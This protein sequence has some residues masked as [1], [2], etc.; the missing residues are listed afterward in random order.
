MRIR[1]LSFILLLSFTLSAYSQSLIDEQK[2]KRFVS[3]AEGALHE[4]NYDSA[5]FYYLQADSIC[6]S[7]MDAT[8][9]N[10]MA[11]VYY[12]L[13][14]YDKAI[15]TCKKAINLDS[16]NIKSYFNLAAAYT[17]SDSLK[18]AIEVYN[19]IMTL[20]SLQK[21]ALFNMGTL[22]YKLKDYKNTVDSYIKVLDIDTNDS[23]IYVNIAIAYASM[24]NN[25]KLLEYMR[26]AAKMGDEEAQEFLSK[27][28]KEW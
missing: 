23:K 1:T 11:G 27:T 5:L 13:K 2:A 7:L 8:T 28:R 22:Y 4:K 10:N 15:Y 16:I 17:A 21:D 12:L 25:D 19:K 6:P 20:D 24:G 18:K 3:L 14:Q 9:Y 26:I